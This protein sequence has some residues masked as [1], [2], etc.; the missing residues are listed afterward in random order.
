V[1]ADADEDGEA[2]G[3][4]SAV[5]GECGS[6]TASLA[7]IA[8]AHDDGG[9]E[10]LSAV[11]VGSS[12]ASECGDCTAGL[13]LIA[14]GDSDAGTALSVSGTTWVLILADGDG[15]ALALGNASAGD[16]VDT[17]VAGGSTNDEGGCDG[18]DYSFCN[19][20]AS[21]VSHTEDEAP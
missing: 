8:D 21:A 19:G 11:A 2:I 18:D 1:T 20:D 10:G 12:Q 15:N 9:D 3:I 7:I 16:G 5:A 4:G 17:A 14:N 6:C 13:G